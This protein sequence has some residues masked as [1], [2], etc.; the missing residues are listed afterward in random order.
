MERL[1]QQDIANGGQQLI[2]K[3]S[4]Q[5]GARLVDL[6]TVASETSYIYVFALAEL[7]LLPW[8]FSVELHP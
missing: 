5:V 1:K 2:D 3:C 7:S 8:G 4:R 6:T